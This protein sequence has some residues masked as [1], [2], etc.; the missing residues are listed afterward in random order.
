MS[1][2]QGMIETPDSAIAT[3]KEEIADLDTSVTVATD[4]RNTDH[5]NFAANSAANQTVA[6][7]L[8]QD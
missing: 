4:M 1:V 5:A 7:L 6:E 8:P 3:P 2:L